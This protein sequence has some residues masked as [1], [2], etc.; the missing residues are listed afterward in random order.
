KG[1]GRL[2]LVPALDH[3]PHRM[4]DTG[5]RHVDDDLM[6]T[7]VAGQCALDQAH[8]VNRT[9]L[10]TLQCAHHAVAAL[11]APVACRMTASA[12]RRAISSC[13][14]P[15]CVNTSVVCWPMAGAGC[16]ARWLPCP[17]GRPGKH[18]MPTPGCWNGWSSSRCAV[19][20]CAA[21]A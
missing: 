6:R 13:P 12:S 7:G 11:A 3:E 20:G 5:I 1:Q 10:V 17:P 21:S 2:G 18:S 16:K 14:R 8:L 9:E 15:A 19:C 4:A